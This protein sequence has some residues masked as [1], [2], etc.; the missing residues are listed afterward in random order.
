MH[1]QAMISRRTM[2]RGLGTAVALPLLEGMLPGSLRAAATAAA[3]PPVRMGFLFVPNGKHMP[4]WTPGEVGKLDKLPPILE[5][6]AKHKQN[7][8]VLSGLTLDGGRSHGD[9]PGDHARCVASFLTGAHPRKTDG[10]NIFNG[11]SVDQAAAERIGHLTRFPSLELGCEP[12]AQAGRC[13]S[14]YSCLYTSN[15][16]WRTPTSPMAKEI[17]PQA[18]FDRLFGA[19]DSSEQDP[20]AAKRLRYRR[21]VL[22][23]VREDAA[24]LNRQLGASD[25][26][27]LDEYLYA[28]RQIERRVTET[29][30]L[31]NSEVDVPD[32]PRP[33]GV[34][35]NI[36]EH[37]RLMMDMSVLALQTDSTRV[38]TFMYTNAGSGRSYP[39]IGVSE[40][41]H[42]LSHHGRNPQKQA[43]ISKINR[44]HVTHLAYFLDRLGS[45]Q[46]GERTLLEN[47]MI[48]Y[49]SGIADGDRHNHEDLPILLAGRGGGAFQTGRHLQYER[50]TPLCNLYVTMLGRMGTNVDKLADSTGMLEDL[51]S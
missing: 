2:L 20:D 21:S 25:Q 34:P 10:K 36:D 50:N 1:F 14:G 44:H 4:D 31:M 40:G 37:V 23:L 35:K 43:K 9:G 47:C 15:M 46:E 22:D 39:Q 6:L 49:G 38:L 33:A 19:S 24:A 29:E 28:V 45:I 8:N 18:V 12:S 51:A 30:K 3:Q 7:I 17:N 16:S 41:H 48:M 32:F 27:K 5:P 13:D 42:G 11:M 26:R